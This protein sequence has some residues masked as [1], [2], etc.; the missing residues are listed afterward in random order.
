M[1]KWGRDL[2]GRACC[3]DM[4]VPGRRRVCED[5]IEEPDEYWRVVLVSKLTDLSW[6]V[7]VAER[8]QSLSC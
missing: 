6:Y 8:L 4:G 7:L 1:G 2:E 3:V 5:D